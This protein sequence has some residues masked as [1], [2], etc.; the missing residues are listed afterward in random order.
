[1]TNQNTILVVD[2]APTNMKM[3]FRLLGA[4]GYK[5]LTAQDGETAMEKARNAKP[6]LILLDVMMPGMDGFEVCRR[7]KNDPKVRDIP[8]IFMTALTDKAD[9]IK[10]FKRGAVDYVTKPLQMEEVLARINAHLTIGNLQTELKK[11][12]LDLAD[13]LKASQLDLA[14]ALEASQA[15]AGEIKLEQVLM[16]LIDIAIEN[17]GAQR[18][19]VIFER[20]EHWVIEEGVQGKGEAMKLRT[21]P[22]AEA[23]KIV[24]ATLINHVA[25]TGENVILQD[26][27]DYIPRDPYIVKHHPKSLACI[28][29]AIHGELTGV[30][31]LENNLATEIFTPARLKMLKLLSSQM[32][33]S[34]E[35]AK[36]Y[37]SLGESEECFR[38]IAETA[39]VSILIARRPDS[40]ILYAN[41]QAGK[42]LGLAPQELVHKY[43]TTDFY[44]NP[45]EDK[46]KLRELLLREKQVRD[47]EL[48]CK[49]KD[50]TPIWITI[51]LEPITFSEEKALFGTFF[52]ITE[53]KRAEEERV[54]LTQ[55]LEIINDQLEYQA[56]KLEQK[57]A[58]RTAK[59]EAQ[60]K[61]L[62]QTLIQLQA[63]QQQ[64]VESEKMAALGNLVAGV[65]H[66]INTPVGIAVTTVSHLDA[67]TE[68]IDDQYVNRT[69][70]RAD[71]E[72]YLNAAKEGNELVLNN[73][74][75]AA[76]LVKSFKQVAVDQSS[77][78]RRMF[79]L[80]EYLHEILTSLR[81]KFKRTR[82]QVDILCDEAVKLDNYPGVFYQIFTNLLMNSLIHG[83]EHLPEGRIT[84]EAVK[85]EQ[86]LL[87]YYRDNGKGIPANTIKNIFDPFFT[88]NR[89]DGGS[90]LGLHIVYNLVTHKL[91]G[92]IRCNSPRGKGVIFSMKIPL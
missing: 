52:D 66:E 47:Y 56:R 78:Q 60:K 86:H 85:E 3:L 74:I 36:L 75:R 79:V 17:S 53:R 37:Q 13:T 44:Y 61:E 41:A 92:T 89:Q 40:L 29:L 30:L 38:I 64:L 49:R 18:G 20:G 65:A 28:S 10:G 90:G 11:A 67:L 19:L 7:L 87:L 42:T 48:E 81:P 4:R 73:L 23:E 1:M 39:P 26:A 54:N 83:F 82:H 91:N 35:H 27:A 31:Y 51:F 57:V 88:T 5:V 45:T 33:V 72:Q 77:E 14:T 71:L 6:D 8:V 76:D 32:A 16:K 68:K 46:P 25:R 58:K 62:E 69:M 34:I 43:K 50:G 12:N 24:P 9:K 63:A 15:L 55:E 84:I 59:I 80:K 21:I 2:D 22:I 70:K